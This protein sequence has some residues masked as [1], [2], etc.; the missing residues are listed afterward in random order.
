M[1][2]LLVFEKM[3]LLNLKLLSLEFITKFNKVVGH[4]VYKLFPLDFQFMRSKI[5]AKILY[6]KVYF[7][8]VLVKSPYFFCKKKKKNKRNV[9]KNALVNLI[10][11][12]RR[13]DLKIGYEM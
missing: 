3:L 1:V 2:K 11:R 5:K 8:N 4:R 12:L 10:W 13:L 7:M 6:T 9:Y